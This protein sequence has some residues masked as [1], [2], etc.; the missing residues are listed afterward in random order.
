MRTAFKIF[1]ALAALH[2]AVTLLAP[3]VT[4][5]MLKM[6]V[7]D[8]VSQSS[9][10]SEQYV[11]IQII[12]YAEE[13]KIPLQSDRVLVWRTDGEVRVWLEY[14][15]RVVL[16]FYERTGHF[17]ITHPEGVE[18]PRRYSHRFTASGR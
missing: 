8:I 13:K 11:R 2:L 14:D 18:V 4:N 17:E 3:H 16:P 6:K 5:R 15:R 1:F 7:R 10:D 12:E 9:T